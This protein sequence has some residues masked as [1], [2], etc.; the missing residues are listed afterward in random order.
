MPQFPEKIPYSP[1]PLG[2]VV[3]Y[4]HIS[5]PDTAFKNEYHF[6]LKL[7]RNNPEV[8]AWVANL[9]DLGDKALADALDKL[10]EEDKLKKGEET[11]WDVYVPIEE[12]TDE[13]V[14]VHLK[15]NAV[16]HTKDGEDKE[17]VI[18]IYDSAD[19]PM[20]RD[21]FIRAGSKVRA[22]CKP[23]AIVVKSARQAGVRLDF[24]KIQVAHLVE[25]EQSGF[26]ST[27][28]GGYQSAPAND[29]RTSNSIP[30]SDGEDTGGDF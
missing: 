12:E 24:G 17:V 30:D 25:R 4:V 23:R 9:K 27:I 11:K 16:I 13:Y 5:K 1:T 22:M 8:D 10:R 20:D 14:V 15:Q 3:G 21:T 6:H 18:G 29:P 26:G 7:L 2:E 19:R 28:E